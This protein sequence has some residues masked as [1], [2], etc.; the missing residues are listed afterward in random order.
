MADQDWAPALG[1]RKAAFS[2]TWRAVLACIVWW[3]LL[4]G[5]HATHNGIGV[6][7]VPTLIALGF[8]ALAGTIT[9][10]IASRGLAETA[11]FVS[12]LLTLLALTFA[13]IAIIGGETIFERA[14]ETS[15]DHLRFI[16]VGGTMI[17]AAVWIGR[18]TLLDA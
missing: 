6:T 14:F 10:L 1:L 5:M 15:T 12:P 9:G 4:W 2:L 8:A 11:G 7:H 3:A 16:I 17:I 13:A 18:N